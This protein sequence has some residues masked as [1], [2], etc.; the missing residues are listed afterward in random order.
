MAIT[1]GLKRTIGLRGLGLISGRFR[2][3]KNN[4][5]VS[6]HWG[7]ILFVGVLVIRALLCLVLET[8][9][10]MAIGRDRALSQTKVENQ[11]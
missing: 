11:P 4:V 10:C 9:M 3:S 1:C 7:G 5:A 6:I 8:H 2:L